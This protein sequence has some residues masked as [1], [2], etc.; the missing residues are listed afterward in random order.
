MIL[1]AFESS[2]W[3]KL[4]FLIAVLS[5]AIFLFNALMRKLLNVERP[6]AFSHNHVND[7]HKKIDWSIRILF[8]FLMLIGG[9]INASRFEEEPYLFLQPYFLL[10]VLIFITE[11][12]RAVMERKYAKNPNAY[13]YTVSQLVFAML[14][15]IVV[16]STDFFG[17]F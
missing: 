11:T 3:L 7:A 10:F 14:L 9:F 12:I 8:I 5:L 6:K 1:Y 4:L 15:V 17:I 16:F 13:L 2:F